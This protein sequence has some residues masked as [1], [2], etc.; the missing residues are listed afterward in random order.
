M[1]STPYL[2]AILACISSLH[3]SIAFS[4][5]SSLSKAFSQASSQLFS[6]PEPLATEGE[7]TAFLDEET[8]GVVYYFNSR[9]G[10]SL[11]EPPTDTFPSVYL[12]PSRRRKAE[13][14]RDEYFR[15]MTP[16]ERKEGGF[17]SSLLGGGNKQEELQT[18]DEILK[19]E[20]EPE[21]MKGMLEEK[22]PA[23]EKK[24]GFFSRL[25]SGPPEPV[26][27]PA[28]APT[29]APEE[30]PAPP[31]NFLD[32]VFQSLTD[33]AVAESEEA[34][35]VNAAEERKALEAQAKA[36][37][38]FDKKRAAEAK[39]QA[40]EEKK[41]AELVR[42]AEAEQKAEADRVEAEARRAEEAE[43]RRLAEEEKIF[44]DDKASTIK[45]DI[46]SF[47]L[48]HPSKVMWGGEDA[49]F[50][51]G[52]T[53][54]VFDGVSGADKVDGLPLYSIM[55][56]RQMTQ[57]V[58]TGNDITIK[59]MQDNL[60]T[61]AETADERA[62]G[63]STAIVASI[64]EDGFLRA[65]NLGDSSCI[66]IRGDRVVAK[67]KEIVHYFDCPYQ[68]SEISPDRP[69]DARKLNFELLKGDVVLMGSD[70]IFDN[71]ED[72]EIVEVVNS[73]PAKAGAIAKQV[74]DLSRKVSLNSNAPTP[75]S[76]QAKR[77]GDPDFRDGL[78]GKV[79]DIS[80]VVAR[81]E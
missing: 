31:K 30:P 73:G 49:V 66:V 40:E 12:K 26:I 56:A 29:P 33:N 61:A 42:K 64:T 48:P 68:L 76:K 37:Q 25:L 16:K 47:V 51:K 58:G 78:G 4:P 21:W 75:Y 39:K 24:P 45:I 54:G 38:D 79:D 81:Y 8:T 71:L 72:S 1:H 28:P 3:G 60:L 27:S 77:N 65:I 9:T 53:F 14:K 11:W 36:K 70:G 80:C 34:A 41:M 35:S 59:D 67:T 6:A 62:T 17:L 50:T 7:W 23:E 44:V 63:A 5:T 57:L 52:R 32:S 13:A 18:G 43:A 20:E 10:E 55:L 46:G 74:S 2:L 22:Y 15:S 69:R 19:E